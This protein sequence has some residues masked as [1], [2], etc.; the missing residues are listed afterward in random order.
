MSPAT[1]TDT[2]ESVVDLDALLAP[3]PGDNPAGENVVYSGLYDQIREARRSEDNLVQGD[4][5]RETKIADWDQVETLA[6]DALTSRTKD[7]QVCAWLGEALIRKYGFKGLRDGL[8]AMRGLHEQFWE[9]VYPEADEGDL[10]A[11][12]NA[13]SWMDRQLGT[14]M[15]EVVLTKSLGGVDFTYIDWE[16]SQ[17]FDIPENVE[18]LDSDVQQRAS[19][20]RQRA[21]EE[22]KVTGEDW[23]KAKNSS[24]RAFYEDLNALVTECWQ[25]F[26]LLDTAI[27]EKFGRQTPGMGDTKKSLES[28]RALVEKLVKEKR[29]LEP[30]PVSVSQA[31][32][33]GDESEGQEVEEGATVSGPTGPIRTRAEALRRLSQIAEYFHKTEPH[34]PV[35]YLVQRAIRWGNMPLE[36]WLQDVIKDGNVLGQL[37]ETL[38]IGASSDG[39]SE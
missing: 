25:E 10:D 14:A 27:D 39:S 7:L 8:K 3:I 34:S 12:A 15:R 32:E 17:Q 23:R 31:V 19:E 16:Q 37:R 24:R 20:T 21:A 30:D 33:G 13:V 4:W 26:N 9:Q 38:G 6:T 18:S 2:A 1:E 22:G 35:S 36:M 11:R 5:K 28:V 29:I